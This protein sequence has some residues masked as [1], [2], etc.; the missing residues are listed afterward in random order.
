MYSKALTRHQ[1]VWWCVEVWYKVNK[2]SKPISGFIYLKFCTMFLHVE[3]P[4]SKVFKSQRLLIISIVYWRVYV[5]R[6][7]PTYSVFFVDKLSFVDW[8]WSLTNMTSTG[9]LFV[10]KCC[11]YVNFKNC[12][13]NFNLMLNKRFWCQ[14]N[15]FYVK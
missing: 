15:V 11:R 7:I 5:I 3:R 14:I 12:V 13:V 10:Q 9:D 2:P 8:Y 4:Y 6:F 1:Q